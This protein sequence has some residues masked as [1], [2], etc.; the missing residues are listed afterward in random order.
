M[1]NALIVTVF[2]S[3]SSRKHKIRWFWLERSVL[4]RS[5]ESTGKAEVCLS[6]L[7]I[8]CSC[9]S[10]SL[11]VRREVALELKMHV[12]RFPWRGRVLSQKLHKIFEGFSSPREQ[13]TA[14]DRRW[15]MHTFMSLVVVQGGKESYCRE[16]VSCSETWNKSVLAQKPCLTHFQVTAYPS[17]LG[18]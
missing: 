12:S 1:H 4:A 15:I 5:I 8:A 17:P 14:G 10:T 13:D 6:F 2:S 3:T 9:G 18:D 11:M 16:W 7:S